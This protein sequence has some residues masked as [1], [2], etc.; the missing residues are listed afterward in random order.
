MLTEQPS[1]L[2]LAQREAEDK[3]LAEIIAWGF[4]YVGKW[5]DVAEGE[6]KK[7]GRGRGLPPVV[8]GAATG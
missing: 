1:S 2:L 4:G 8:I 3:L 7:C 5:A 6:E